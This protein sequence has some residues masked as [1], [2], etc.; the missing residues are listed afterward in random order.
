MMTRM[1][2]EVLRSIMEVTLI[3]FTKNW[4]E[5]FALSAAHINTAHGKSNHVLQSF[6]RIVCISCGS[7]V[8]WSVGPEIAHSVDG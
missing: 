5:R 8:V 7:K 3:S 1:L 6:K 2:T 4:I